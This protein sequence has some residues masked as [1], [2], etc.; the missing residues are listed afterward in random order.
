[1]DLLNV[2]AKKIN[3]VL[4]SSFIYGSLNNA[5]CSRINNE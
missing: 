2:R 4:S 1:M 5:D 3:F